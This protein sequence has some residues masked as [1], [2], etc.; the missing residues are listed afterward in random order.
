MFFNNIEINQFLIRL[1]AI[2]FVLDQACTTY[3]AE[4]GPGKLLIWLAKPKMSCIENVCLIKITIEWVK[5]I[6]FGPWSLKKN[7]PAIKFELCTPVLGTQELVCQSDSLFCHSEVTSGIQIRG[8][9]KKRLE[10]GRKRKWS[11]V[12]TCVFRMAVRFSKNFPRLAKTSTSKTTLYGQCINACVK[13]MFQRAFKTVN[14]EVEPDSRLGSAYSTLSNKAT[15][16]II[17]SLLLTQHSYGN[18]NFKKV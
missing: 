18:W 16:S 11:S 8:L 9:V 17:H 2:Y 5:H 14:E 7:W 4:C 6:N 12:A 13:G 15:F 10:G 3:W 1:I